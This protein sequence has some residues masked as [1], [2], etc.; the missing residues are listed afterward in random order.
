MAQSAGMTLAPSNWKKYTVKDEDFAVSLPTIPAMTTSKNS[1]PRLRKARLE[2]E[3]KTSLDG[4]VYSIG[5]FD[6]PNPKQSLDEFVAEQNS[7]SAYDVSAER[8]LTIDGVAGK[9]YLSREKPGVAQFFATERRLYRFAAI[10]AGT[11]NEAVKKF[12]SSIML[13]KH[14]YGI[15]VSDGPGMPLESETGDRIFKGSEVDTKPRI[16]AK[17]E[18]QYTQNAIQNKTRGTVVLLVVLHKTGII[19]NIQVV[20]GLPNGLTEVA[21]EAAKKVK[22]TPAVKDDKYVSMWMTLEYNFNF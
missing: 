18:P 22:F 9:E 1:Q 2:R 21:I 4:V 14:V 12:F 5:V 7:N 17:P 16:T 20:K 10:G 19:N 8:N 6:N 13:G 3:L 11:D 15:E